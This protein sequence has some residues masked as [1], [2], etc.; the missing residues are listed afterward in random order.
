MVKSKVL[1]V[2]IKVIVSAAARVFHPPVLMIWGLAALAAAITGPFNT[3]TTLDFAARALFWGMV[4]GGSVFLSSVLRQV[5]DHFAPDLKPFQR[6]A[7]HV[8]GMTILLAPFIVMLGAL[9]GRNLTNGLFS[10][11]KIA[12]FVLLI[13]MI[14]AALR[15]I[16]GGRELFGPVAQKE[17]ADPVMDPLGLSPEIEEPSPPPA[18]SCR[19]M[20]RM[21]VGVVGEILHLSARDHFVD[22]ELDQS[23]VSLRM[24]FSDAVAEMD[25]VE[26]HL[27]H[28]SHWVVRRAVRGSERAEGK[29]FLILSNDRRVPVSRSM[30]PKLEEAGYMDPAS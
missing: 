14:I 3:F 22:V 17:V 23:L 15:Q 2:L 13:S 8:T 5:V 4:S 28:R 16:Y 1:S 6:E 30:K 11:W 21:P 29:L 26:G 25:G 7:F 24:R 20:S 18:P 12:F 10:G 27:T 9:F 19:L